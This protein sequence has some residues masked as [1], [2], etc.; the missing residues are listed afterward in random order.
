MRAF[1]VSVNGKKLCLAGIGD[2]GVLT[3]IVNCVTRRG[4]GNLFL[5]VGGLFSPTGEHVSW[6]NQK[7]LLVGD[8]V[9]VKVVE[10]SSADAPIERHRYSIRKNGEAE[11]G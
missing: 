7:P 10:T 1:E 9:Q 4:A 8:E 2:D 5:E 6:I 3:T 11:A